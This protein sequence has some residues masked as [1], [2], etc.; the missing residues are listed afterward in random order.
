M[1][2]RSVRSLAVLVGVIVVALGT[3]HACP[4]G[5]CLKYRHLQPPPP[6]APTK[7][8]YLRTVHAALPRLDRAAIA[9]FLTGSTWELSGAP[10]ATSKLR[11]V[12]ATRITQGFARPPER[13]IR[14]VLVRTI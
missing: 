6:P 8:V 5:P 9:S 4:P 14:T 12:D 11:F 2:G 7:V 13:T 3:A 1:S 10:A